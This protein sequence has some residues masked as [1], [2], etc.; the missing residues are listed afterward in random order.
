MPR[1]LSAKP[2][3]HAEEDVTFVFKDNVMEKGIGI[4]ICTFYLVA[5]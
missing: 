1:F 4:L 5:V 2:N 3:D